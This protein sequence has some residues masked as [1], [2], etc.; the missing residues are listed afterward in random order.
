V[1]FSAGVCVVGDVP[2]SEA[3]AAADVALYRAKQAGRSCWRFAE[4]SNTEIPSFR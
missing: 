4:P 3:I 1:T 2:A